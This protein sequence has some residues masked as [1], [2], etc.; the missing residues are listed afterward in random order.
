MVAAVAAL[1]GLSSLSKGCQFDIFKALST[2]FI[3]SVGFCV[4]LF[5]KSIMEGHLSCVMSLCSYS[6]PRYLDSSAIASGLA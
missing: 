3:D 2:T 6:L 1:Q 5:S 4:I